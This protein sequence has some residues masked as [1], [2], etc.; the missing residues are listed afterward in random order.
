[1]I[2]ISDSE[3][4]KLLG[5]RLSEVIVEEPE[6]FQ[7]KMGGSGAFIFTIPSK[8]HHKV[9]GTLLEKLI[10]FFNYVPDNE[11]K[12]LKNKKATI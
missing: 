11:L 9:E 1:M 5:E 4:V 10:I 8:K 2:S 3:G 7:C 12:S 6:K